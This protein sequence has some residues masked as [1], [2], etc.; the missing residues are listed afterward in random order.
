ML[1]DFAKALSDISEAY[2]FQAEGEYVSGVGASLVN[3]DKATM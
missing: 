1:D 3:K 2:I